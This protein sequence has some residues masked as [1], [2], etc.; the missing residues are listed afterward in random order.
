MWRNGDWPNSGDCQLIDNRFWLYNWLKTHSKKAENRLALFPITKMDWVSDTRSKSI[1]FIVLPITI[2]VSQSLFTRQNS[3][4]E[5]LNMN[6]TDFVFISIADVDDHSI[7]AKNALIYWNLNGSRIV[8]HIQNIRGCYTKIHSDFVRIATTTT[9]INIDKLKR[10]F[11]D[12]FNCII[13]F[14]F[15]LFFFDTIC[16]IHTKLNQSCLIEIL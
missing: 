7:W 16:W 1:N 15:S 9:K 11:E 8:L 4:F 5:H 14:L 3:R 2:T 10:K 6:L 12:I 13:S